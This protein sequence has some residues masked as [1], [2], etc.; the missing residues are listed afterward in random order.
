MH[1]SLRLCVFVACSQCS[2]TFVV[3]NQT[4]NG[5]HQQLKVVFLLTSHQIGGQYHSVP[6]E[7]NCSRRADPCV[8]VLAVCDVHAC[9]CY[10][11][12]IAVI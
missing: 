3:E 10:I 9:R 5:P 8:I 2:V 12:F 4:S 1:I 6:S 7:R 11:V